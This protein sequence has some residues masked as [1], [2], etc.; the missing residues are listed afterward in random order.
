MHNRYIFTTILEAYLEQLDIGVEV[1]RCPQ[2]DEIKPTVY[3]LTPQEITLGT[4]TTH[5]YGFLFRDFFKLENFKSTD[6]H[7]VIEAKYFVDQDELEIINT[8]LESDDFWV[9]RFEKL[10]LTLQDLN[11]ITAESAR[12]SMLRGKYPQG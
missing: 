10:G 7:L 4:Y 9:Q 5:D 1:N 11:K 3:A 8:S 6:L 12:V 2:L